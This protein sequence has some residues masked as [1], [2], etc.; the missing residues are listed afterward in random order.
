MRDTT[1]LHEFLSAHT[2]LKALK[3]DCY[4]YRRCNSRLCP[5]CDFRHA[6]A[7]RRRLHAP[8]SRAVQ[9]TLTLPDCEDVSIGFDNLNL[10]RR[11]FERL[12]RAHSLVDAY[13]VSFELTVPS[14]WHWHLH[15]AVFGND[16]QGLLHTLPERWVASA[17]SLGFQ[18]SRT[19]QHACLKKANGPKGALAYVVKGKL[20]RG[21]NSLRELLRGASSGESESVRLWFE[22]ESFMERGK[23]W[24]STWRMRPLKSSVEKKIPMHSTLDRRLMMLA[25]LIGADSTRPQALMV[26]TSGDSLSR[27]T[28]NRIRR[29]D[30]EYRQWRAIRTFKL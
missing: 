24:L 19:A 29:D 25:D 27:A 7:A 28:I 20:G 1:P 17:Q 14:L 26:T 9:L 8:T 12:L 22:F 5:S 6:D 4:E 18:A 13:V 21:A 30:S 11:E 2:T 16:L 23:H 10:V 15:A 3:R